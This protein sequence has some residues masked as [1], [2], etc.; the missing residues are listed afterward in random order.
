MGKVAA[1]FFKKGNE[2][3]FLNPKNL[4]ISSLF[5]AFLTLPPIFGAI[6][7]LVINFYWITVILLVLFVGS[8]IIVN[9]VMRGK[10][11]CKHCKQG[12]IGCPAYQKFV[13][14]K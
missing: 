10:F 11:G 12:G 6:V 3:E 2:R 14:N 8:M 5:D 4:M 9:A 13:K 1:R 7:L